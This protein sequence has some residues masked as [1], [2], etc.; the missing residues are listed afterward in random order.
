V[1]RVLQRWD[2]HYRERQ[3]AT[4]SEQDHLP[5]NGHL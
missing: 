2:Q 1:N 5:A 3:P 4:R